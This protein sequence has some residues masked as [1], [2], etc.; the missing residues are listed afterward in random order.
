MLPQ[1]L[2][3]VSS[4]LALLSCTTAAPPLPE[5][6][7][8]G[9]RQSILTESRFT[10]DDLGKSCEAIGAEQKANMAKIDGDNKA[11]QGNRRQNEVA[12]Y[13]GALLV[14]PLVATESNAAEKD[15]IA[16]LQA[17]QDTLLQLQSFKK[18]P[19]RGE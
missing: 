5:D 7:T 14:V 19:V 15:D 10:P 16:A 4:V 11:I 2:I 1:R 13:L 9:N 8:S 17:R 12:G 6:T 18:C 3:A